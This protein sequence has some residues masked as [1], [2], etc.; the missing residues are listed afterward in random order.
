MAYISNIKKLLITQR[1][2]STENIITEV[3]SLI[4]VRDEEYKFM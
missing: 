4:P 2:G 1:L 3:A